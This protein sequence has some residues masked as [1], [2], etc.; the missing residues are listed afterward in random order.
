MTDITDM[1]VTSISST[2]GDWDVFGNV[3][4]VTSGA[5]TVFYMN[6]WIGLTSATANTDN[7]QVGIVQYGTAGLL[8]ANTVIGIAPTTQ[9]ISLASTTTVYLGAV[10]HFTGGTSQS[11]YGT[12]TAR[13]RR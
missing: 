13:R 2:A 7:T 12:I 11:A 5:V 4:A 8:M 10:S 6:T 9:R 3:K 1:N